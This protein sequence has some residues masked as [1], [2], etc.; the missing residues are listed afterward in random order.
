MPGEILKIF[1]S[2]N[3]QVQIVRRVDGAFTFRMRS[4]SSHGWNRPGP[5]CGI[6]DSRET[7]EAE[8][9]ARVWW[10]AATS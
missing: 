10:L 4:K 1:E 2:P 9:R 5:D 8:A 3:A 7:A 6:Y